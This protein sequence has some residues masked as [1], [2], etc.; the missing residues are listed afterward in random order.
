[1]TING[2]NLAP[3]EGIKPDTLP[4]PTKLG[5]PAIEVLINNRPAPIVSAT[6]SRITVQVPLEIQNGYATV[7][8]RRGDQQSRVARV[9][10]QSLS[11]AVISA[12]SL[13]FGPV[14][15]TGTDSILKLRATSIGPAEPRVGNGEVAAEATPPRATIRVYAAGLLA[16]TTTTYSSTSPGEFDI[17]VSLPEGTGAGDPILL[18]ANSAEANLVTARR[19]PTVSETIYIPF[20]AGT[21]DL[22]SLRSSDARGLF[23][24]ANAI[25]GADTCY[26]SFTIDAAK[27]TFRKVDGCLTSAQAQTAT[28]FTE[29]VGA[30]TF[31][32]FE[33]PFTGTVQVGQAAPVSASVRLFHP[34]Q[35]MPV[36][37]VLPSA[38]SNLNSTEGGNFIAVVPGAAGAAAKNYRIDARSG[39]VEEVMPGGAA[40]LGGVN[41]QALLQRFQSLD[42]GDGVDKLLSNINIINNQVVLTAGDNQDNP[43]KAKVAILTVQG[44]LVSKRDF[45]AG[46]LPIAAPAAPQQVL[47][48][49]IQFPGGMQLP[50]GFAQLR[51][52]TPV[53]LEQQTRSYYVAARD[54]DGHHGFVYFAAEGDGKVIPLPENWY[55]TSCVANMPVF[56][57]DLARGI[58]ML[59]SKLEDRAFKNPCAADG[60]LLFDLA[61]RT[62]SAASLPGSGKFNA[63]GS[64]SEMNDFLIGANSDPANRNTSDTLFALDG[65]NGSV[66]RFDLPAG[67]NNFSQG[68]PIPLLNLLVAQAN[69]RANANGDAGLVLF[70]LERT[71]SRLLPTP[72]GFAT[73]AYVGL[74]PSLRKLVARGIKTGNT[75]SQILI[76]NLDN[77]DLEFVA[78]P[79]GVAWAGSPPQQAAPGGQGQAQAGNI[80]VRVNQKANT[81]EAVA[82]GED[83]KQR[84]A[85]VVRVY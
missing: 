48:G 47:P 80:P 31:A 13:G 71:E 70:D 5:D 75:G 35:E 11:P 23:L 38:A 37:A 50:A 62:F 7:I 6:P 63:T 21:P 36:T 41:A 49:G 77:G 39:S 30:S 2:I 19:G 84:G 18:V 4:L 16:A 69:N 54:A 44:D 10:I 64:A 15:N 29:S 76:Y 25:R 74:F 65:V 26:P 55:F 58:A 51:M 8:V 61:V 73:I 33:G 43:T 85:M 22:R 78:N 1:M 20:P 66:F 32:A 67:V 59:G 53:Y 45:P 28:P 83:R 57:V 42:L 17:E 34:S 24:Y 3:P 14:E 72:E 12:N 52:R 82:F 60:F 68:T 56:S 9:Q 40:A 79:D 46:W 27:K 81:I